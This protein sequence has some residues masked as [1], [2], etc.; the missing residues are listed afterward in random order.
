MYPSRRLEHQ[1]SDP[2]HTSAPGPLILSLL[3]PL[4]LLV[5]TRKTSV[6]TTSLAHK[7]LRPPIPGIPVLV[8]TPINVMRLCGNLTGSEVETRKSHV[9]PEISQISL[10][11]LKRKEVIAR[12]LV[13]RLAL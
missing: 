4:L 12:R 6:M 2:L 5:S 9:L 13:V 1:E 3:V 7:L 8:V 10:I 11:Q